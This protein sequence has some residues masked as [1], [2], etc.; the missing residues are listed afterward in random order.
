MVST[1]N[2]VAK[3]IDFGSKFRGAREYSIYGWA[4]WVE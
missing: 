1:V 2:S 4:K 3:E